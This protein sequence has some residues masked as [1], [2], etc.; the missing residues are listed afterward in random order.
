MNL[1]HGV[2]SGHIL[3]SVAGQMR[4][5]AKCV[6]RP[7][8]F[9]LGQTRLAWKTRLNAFGLGQMRFHYFLKPMGVFLIK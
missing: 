9:G 1:E 8:A 2:D 3:I 6:F 7:N 5:Q 4:F